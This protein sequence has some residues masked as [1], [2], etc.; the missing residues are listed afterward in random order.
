MEGIMPFEFKKTNIE[1]VVLIIPKVF[2][3][4]RG[5]FLEGYKKSDFINNG[6]T[7][8]FNQDNHSKS[9]L[10]VLRGLHYQT[11]PKLQAKIVRC[12]RGKIFDVAVD[13]RKNSKTF[14]KWTGAILS[15]ENKNMLYIP[16]GFAH[17]FL[18]L[19]DT[20]ELLYKASGEYS[21]QNDRGILW[22]DP[23]INIDWQKYGLNFDPTLSDKDKK[24]PLLKDIKEEDLL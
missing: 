15:E 17:G 11:K 12:I 18:T 22:N 19:S 24:Q 4:N 14:G 8:D 5:F 2:E 9:S 20:A 7:D 6:I 21:P 13:I 3:D 10:G 23:Q 16:E 1:D